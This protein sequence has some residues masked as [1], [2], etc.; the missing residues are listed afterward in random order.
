MKNLSFYF[1]YS[2]TDNKLAHSCTYCTFANDIQH[3]YEKCT[4]YMFICVYVLPYLQYSRFKCILISGYIKVIEILNKDV[5]FFFSSWKLDAFCTFTWLNLQ[6]CDWFKPV[7]FPFQARLTWQLKSLKCLYF[8][9]N[10]SESNSV[11]S[12]LQ[13]LILRLTFHCTPPT[14]TSLMI[15]N[16]LWIHTGC[17]LLGNEPLFHVIIK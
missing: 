4:T 2:C 6:W 3:T 8:N 13:R 1:S 5:F 9:D 15:H 11:C 14:N 10:C 16:N 7:L 12:S 17:F